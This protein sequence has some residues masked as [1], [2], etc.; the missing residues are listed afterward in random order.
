V[1]ASDP[2]FCA[3]ANI[4][5]NFSK[6][7]FWL[8]IDAAQALDCS[9]RGKPRVF[10]AER[11]ITSEIA[12]VPAKDDGIVTCRSGNYYNWKQFNLETF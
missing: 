9:I 10:M 7:F 12:M 6:L 4:A 5:E 1:P 2:K 11:A 3:P 8:R